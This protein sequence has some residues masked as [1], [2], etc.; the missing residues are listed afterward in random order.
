M[1]FCH[2]TLDTGHA[3]VKYLR[4]DAGFPVKRDEVVG[5]G[6]SRNSRLMRELLD[7]MRQESDLKAALVDGCGN[8]SNLLISD[9]PGSKSCFRLW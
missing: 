3:G 6:W 2:W 7:Y 4:Q 8:G 1:N 5:M 9:N